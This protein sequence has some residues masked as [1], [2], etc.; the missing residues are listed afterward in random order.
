MAVTD[1]VVDSVDVSDA[2][3]DSVDVSDTVIDSVDVSETVDDLVDVFDAVVVV[4]LVAVLV[5]ETVGAE[6]VDFGLALVALAE[7][8]AVAAI[9]DNI[10]D[11]SER[12][13]EAIDRIDDRSESP[14]A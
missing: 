4:V 8:G 11:A 7:I 12:A 1:A 3:V 5:A 14:A 2:V 6:P 13:A 10:A 9:D